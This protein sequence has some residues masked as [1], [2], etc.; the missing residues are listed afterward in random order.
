MATTTT[1]H[2][3]IHPVTVQPSRP[4]TAIVTVIPDRAPKRMFMLDQ[5]ADAA[6]DS[7]PRVWAQAPFVN[8]GLT[9]IEIGMNAGVGMLS[10]GEVVSF[11]RAG[12]AMGP[13]AVPI[14]WC[15]LHSPPAPA[16]S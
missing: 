7:L 5:P 9:T 10:T 14:T 3:S 6:S 4:P 2:P 13:S 1:V 15:A 8:T 16:L 12:Q 11:H